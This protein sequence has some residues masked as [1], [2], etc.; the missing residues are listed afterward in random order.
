[1]SQTLKVLEQLLE[2]ISSIFTEEGMARYDHVNLPQNLQMDIKL[3]REEYHTL[4]RS[5]HMARKE[6]ARCRE[7]Q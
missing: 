3:T 6:V 7:P 2:A 1:M 4:R 5:M